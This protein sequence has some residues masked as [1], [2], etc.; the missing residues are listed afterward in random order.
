MP[1]FDIPIMLK[2]IP[3]GNELLFAH[4]TFERSAIEVLTEMDFN[5]GSAVV[6]LITAINNAVKFIL[7][8]MGI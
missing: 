3:F 6:F 1:T 7:V 2:E 8:F 4:V 5:V